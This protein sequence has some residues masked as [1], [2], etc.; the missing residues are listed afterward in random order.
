MFCQARSVRGRVVWKGVGVAGPLLLRWWPH[1]LL[2]AK[3]RTIAWS[4]RR[5]HTTHMLLAR[6]CTRRTMFLVRQAARS[7][8]SMMGR[9]I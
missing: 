2:L 6:R 4:T 9:T 1:R 5:G 7:R 8:R 3:W